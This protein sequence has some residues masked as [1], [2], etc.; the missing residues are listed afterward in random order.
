MDKIIKITLG[1]FIIILVAFVASVSYTLYVDNTYRTSLSSTYS[2]Q[3]TIMTNAVLSNVTLFVPV[4]AFPSGNSPVIV[5]I[6][7]HEINGFPDNWSAVLFDTGKATLLQ[8][9]AAQIGRPPVNGNPVTTNVTFFVDAN[10]SSLIDTRSPIADGAVFRPVQNPM[11]TTCPSAGAGETTGL[12]N[13]TQYTTAVYATYE[14]APMA[15]VSIHASVTG[16][17]AWLVFHPEFNEYRNTFD[18][19]LSGTSSGWVTAQARLE[20]SI[21]SYDAPQIFL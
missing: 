13:C 2:Y 4:P 9:T 7:S 16:R 1:L 3:C 5:R 6:S 10:S 14:T 15:S 18:A 21:G 8:I 12:P 11:D 17:N 19:T 20:Y